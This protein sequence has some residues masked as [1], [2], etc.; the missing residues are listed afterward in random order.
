[1]Y[2][3][4][5]WTVLPVL[6]SVSNSRIFF[7]S[8]TEGGKLLSTTLQHVVLH[9]RLERTVEV[10]KGIHFIQGEH[11][12]RQKKHDIKTVLSFQ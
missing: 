11:L 1:M 4:C 7:E 2:F 6:P 8:G 10:L 5:M 12:E 3:H 9:I